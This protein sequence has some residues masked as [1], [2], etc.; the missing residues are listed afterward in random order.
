MRS[1]LNDEQHPTKDTG[2]LCEGDKNYKPLTPQGLKI[3]TQ[4]RQSRTYLRSE[5]QMHTFL[6]R[7]YDPKIAIKYHEDILENMENGNHPLV[8]GLSNEQIKAYFTIA[9]YQTVPT[10]FQEPISLK[11]EN[12]P[13]Q[14]AAFPSLGK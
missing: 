10:N 8:S 6:F 13:E 2:Y 1:N 12:G 11:E 5:Q 7:E 4:I 14:A 9:E 3:V